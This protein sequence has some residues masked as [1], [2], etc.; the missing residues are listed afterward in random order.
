MLLAWAG[1]RGLGVGVGRLRK[2]GTDGRNADGL[3]RRKGGIGGGRREGLGKVRR[4]KAA[5][6]TRKVGIGVDLALATGVL[7]VSV[8]RLRKGPTDGRNADGPRRRKREGGRGRKG[9]ISRRRREGLGKTWRRKVPI[10]SRK[11]GIGV[12]ID[13]A[14]AGGMAI[15]IGR[16]RMWGT[17]ERNAGGPRRRKREGGRRRKGGISRG[18]REGL[19]KTRRRMVAI[20]MREVGIGV[21]ID[22][23]LAMGLVVGVGWLR[24]GGTIGRNAAGSRRRKRGLANGRRNKAPAAIG[25][26][27]RDGCRKAGKNDCRDDFQL[28]IVFFL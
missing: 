11:V 7:I 26:R 3:R 17:D 6:S 9:G 8:S 25:W 18:R 28:H 5:I 13:L 16:P 22:L 15:G 27:E 20:C 24:K 4:R 19:G 14:L 23:A 10:C 21:E 2:G 1:A 12:D